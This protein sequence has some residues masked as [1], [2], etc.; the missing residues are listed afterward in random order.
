M[1]A[2]NGNNVKYQPRMNQNQSPRT[3]NLTESCIIIR[4]L[5]ET[6]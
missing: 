1:D 2:T 4:L 6:E 3:R 5:T